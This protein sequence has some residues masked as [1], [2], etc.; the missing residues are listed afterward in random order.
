MGRRYLLTLVSLCLLAPLAS[1]HAADV[2]IEHGVADTYDGITLD[3]TFAHPGGETPL[4]VIMVGHDWGLSRVTDFTSGMTKTFL[5]AGYAVLTWD[6]RGFGTSG[7]EANLDGPDHEVRD[8]M[9]L[10]TTLAGRADVLLDGEGDPRVGMYGEGYA[11]TIQLMAAAA[12]ERIDALVPRDAWNDLPEALK[13][14]GVLK[15]NWDLLLL[16]SGV[17]GGTAGGAA[18]RQIGSVAPQLPIAVAEGLALNDWSTGSFAWFE[19]RSPRHYI[20]GAQLGSRTFPGVSAP[21]LLLHDVNNTFASLRHAIATHG[22][23]VERGVTTKLVASC[24]A[25]LTPLGTSC[26]TGDAQEKITAMSL[27]WFARHLA[28]DPSADTGP[29]VEYQLQDGSFAS[30]AALPMARFSGSGATRLTNTVAP[31]SGQ[32]FGGTS[33]GCRPATFGESAT[34]YVRDCPYAFGDWVEIAQ[35]AEAADAPNCL[36]FGE[37]PPPPSG[38]PLPDAPLPYCPL[39]NL[40]MPVGTHL[41]GN[42][43]VDLTVSGIGLEGYIFF[44]LVDYDTVAKTKTVVDDQVTALKIT[45]PPSGFSTRDIRVTMAGVSWLVRQGHHIYLELTPTSNDHASSRTPFN[46]TLSPIEIAMPAIAPER[47]VAPTISAPTESQVVPATGATATVTVTGTADPAATVR[48]QRSGVRLASVKAN[49]VT[50]AWTASIKVKN[51]QVHAITA[52]QQD[53]AGSVSEKT[54]RLTFEVVRI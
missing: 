12:D 9:T 6:A 11:G 21:T 52:T 35:F 32:V 51:D 19:E 44:K 45:G 2:R 16:G 27:A 39:E 41:L 8:V 50:G 30:V 5:D 22:T 38:G 34:T 20:D 17:A 42:P 13:P 26:V 25:S 24:G 23:L 54:E 43:V 1:A 28:G 40:H 18:T 4:P 37:P 33:G 7:G 53:A 3:Y 36:V 31:T 46:L 47:P 49:A 10:V 29:A 15:N 14:G 48:V